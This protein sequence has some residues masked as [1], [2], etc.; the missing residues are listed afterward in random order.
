VRG[1]LAGGAT[2]TDEATW[3]GMKKKRKKIHFWDFNFNFNFFKKPLK[4]TSK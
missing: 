4:S 1:G 2:R 3:D